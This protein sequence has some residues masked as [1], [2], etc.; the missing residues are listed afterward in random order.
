MRALVITTNYGTEQ[1]ELLSPAKA[2]KDAGAEVTVAATED[3][4]IKTLVSDQDP[5]ETLTPDAAIGAVSHRDFDLLVIPGGTIN[6]DSLRLNEPAQELVKAFAADGKTIAAICH[7]PWL[8]VETGLVSG[9]QLTSYASVA[10]DI[11]NAGGLWHD[12]ELVTCDHNGWTLITSRSPQDLPA[13]N[14]ALTALA[15]A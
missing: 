13:F 15:Q 4:P 7:G 1:D 9:K 14:A 2:L 5:G 3:A 8:L 11:R 12:R 10:T 6:A